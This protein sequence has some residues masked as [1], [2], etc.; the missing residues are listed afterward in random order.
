MP[1]GFIMALKTS[2]WPNWAGNCCLGRVPSNFQS[3][4]RWFEVAQR[5]WRC[6]K[7]IWMGKFFKMFW[8]K[9]IINMVIHMLTNW[10]SKRSRKKLLKT[11]YHLEHVCLA[12]TF[13]EASWV[14]SEILLLCNCNLISGLNLVVFNAF[15][16][17]FP[18]PCWV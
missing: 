18:I 6:V 7:K 4:R 8:T 3:F 15:V 11:S 5:Q 13:D 16:S 17:L 12:W 9:Q 1:L 2:W 10:T 14:V